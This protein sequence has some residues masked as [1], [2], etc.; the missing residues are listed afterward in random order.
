MR[1]LPR[2]GD[3]SEHFHLWVMARRAGMMRG[4]GAVLAFWDDVLPDVS[5]ELIA[6]HHRIVAGSLAS[7]G[8]EAFPDSGGRSAGQTGIS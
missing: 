7:R 5:A 1:E 3:G 6:E 8:G 4:R 2:W